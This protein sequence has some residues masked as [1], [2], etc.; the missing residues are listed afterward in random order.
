MSEQEIEVLAAEVHII[1]C[2]QYKKNNGKPY[3]T[4]GDY[5]LLDEPTKDYDRA[6]VRWHLNRY[7]PVLIEGQMSQKHRKDAEAI[8]QAIVEGKESDRLTAE[9]QLVLIRQAANR[10]FDDFKK[11][12]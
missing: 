1:Y 9:G 3:R 6:F 5:S 7:K 4:N 12:R 8:L 2:D 11:V 10:Y